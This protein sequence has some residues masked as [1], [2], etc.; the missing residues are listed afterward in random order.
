MSE[1]NK[2]TILYII[3]LLFLITCP[4]NFHIPL[5]SLCSCC[6]N[7]VPEAEYII[8]NKNLCITVL[9]AGKYQIKVLSG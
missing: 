1:S 5:I 7:K 8:K 6:H 9:E 3:R 2:K 4:I